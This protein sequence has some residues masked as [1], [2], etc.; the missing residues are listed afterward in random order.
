[1]KQPTPPSKAQPAAP[2]D[3][4]PWLAPDEER[5]RLLQAAVLLA[6]AVHLW[7]F[8]IA[9]PRLRQAAG[10]PDIRDHIHVLRLENLR[11]EQPKPQE[12][13]QVPPHIIHVPGGDN[14]PPEI[15]E[16]NWPPPPVDLGSQYIPPVES[17]PPP[18][19]AAEGPRI[20]DVGEIEAPRVL[21]RVQP[22][23]T[24][25]AIA[26]RLEGAVILELVIGE[27]GTVESVRV[28]R[29]LPLGLTESAVAAVRRWRFE[30]STLDGRP[31]KVRYRLTIHFQLR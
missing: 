25:A 28:L 29:R 31:I 20:V 26:A 11:L 27:E 3:L 18:P 17:I 16:R 19:P 4:F 23:Y 30:P 13:I 14:P 7:L 9:W 12:E 10:P 22:A 24:R 6:V 2:A 1:M 5:R 15:I 8:A 21:E